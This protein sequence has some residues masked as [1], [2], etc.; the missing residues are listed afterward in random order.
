MHII[1]NNIQYFSFACKC[2]ALKIQEKKKH[3]ENVWQ[4]DALITQRFEPD[5]LDTAHNRNIAFAD[6]AKQ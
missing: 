2:F 1:C 4:N 5:H 3:P 6:Q